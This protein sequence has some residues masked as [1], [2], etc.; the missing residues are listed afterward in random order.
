M[1]TR[2]EPPPCSLR[3][4]EAHYI[5]QSSSA[6]R[7]TCRCGSVD[8]EDKEQQ[9]TRAVHRID[10]GPDG[11]CVPVQVIEAVLGADLKN[12]DGTRFNTY[13]KTCACE[14]HELPRARGG[15]HQAASKQARVHQSPQ[16]ENVSSDVIV[17][18]ISVA[19]TI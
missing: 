17:H 12:L 7:S 16:E 19:S 6:A 1:M 8:E 14:K 13:P 3:L 5:C 4:Q 2:E 9:P 15:G 11:S 10:D 18:R